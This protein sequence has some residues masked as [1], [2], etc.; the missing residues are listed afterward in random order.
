MKSATTFLDEAGIPW[1]RMP[2]EGPLPPTWDG[3]VL[4]LDWNESRDLKP[5]SVGWAFHEISHY[6]LAPPSSRSLPNYG[7]GTDPGGGGRTC[8]VPGASRSGRI[9]EDEGSACVLDVLRMLDAGLEESVIQ[10]H[11]Y[12]YGIEVPAYAYN[13]LA[14]I[15]YSREVVH[16]VHAWIHEAT[17]SFKPG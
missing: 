11:V 17:M 4:T 1:R 16:Q 14:E 15:G 8:A 13:I 12:K 3:A 10:L 9:H 6:L 7:L 5:D 2:E